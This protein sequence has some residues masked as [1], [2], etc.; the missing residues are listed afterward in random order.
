[1]NLPNEAVTHDGS[2]CGTGIWGDEWQENSNFQMGIFQQHPLFHFSG[3]FEVG[4]SF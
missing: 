1:M 3:L 4:S 2:L